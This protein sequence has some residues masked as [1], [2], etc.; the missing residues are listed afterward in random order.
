MAT[1]QAQKSRTRELL[2]QAALACEADLRV[3]DVT[4]LAGVAHGTFYVHFPSTGALI[5]E[6]LVDFNRELVA[7]V[8]A[9]LPGEA[10]SIDDIL[11]NIARAYFDFWTSHRAHLDLYAQR[12]AATGSLHQMLRSTNDNV[13]AWTAGA[14]DAL[15][16]LGGYSAA[17]VAIALQAVLA[18]WQRVGLGVVYDGLN[19][20]DAVAPLVRITRG[21]LLASFPVLEGVPAGMLLS[22]LRAA[23]Q[24]TVAAQSAG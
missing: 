24:Q 12:L 23:G 18:V 10:A 3:Q 20:E 2:K 17:E 14:V 16:A 9:A 8:I 1:R 4:R 21:I 5:D 7:V 15:R 13:M 11:A 19:P 22:A 6:L